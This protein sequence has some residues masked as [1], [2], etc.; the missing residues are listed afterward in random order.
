M[1][2][3]VSRTLVR[4]CLTVGVCHMLCCV[5]LTQHNSMEQCRIEICWSDFNVKNLLYVH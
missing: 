1:S 3:C 4:M 2:Y 5:R